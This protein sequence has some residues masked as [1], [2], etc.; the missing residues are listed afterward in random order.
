MISRS[1]LLSALVAAELL[2]GF[3]MVAFETFLPPRLAQLSTGGS[4]GAAQLVGPVVT[5]A[6]VVSAAGAA[7]SPRLV[8]RLGS[9][10]AGFWLRAVQ[11]G[12]V[13]A[14]GLATGIAGLVVA[15]L[16]NYGAHG[17]TNPV[18]YGM[19]HRAVDGAHRATVVSANSLTAQVG[20]AVSGIA[21]GALA[22]ASSLGL[23][24]VVAGTVLAAAAPLYLA[25]RRPQRAC[26]E[27]DR[28][29]RP[30]QSPR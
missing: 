23:A 22:D 29:W 18:H 2:W 20:G 24:M 6:W 27:P 17:A 14:M 16:A 30:A 1:R 3:G 10:W 28:A 25:G 9:A 13:V 7:V 19:V 5:V 11:G 12:A 21:L 4:D 8:N 26:P 15:Y